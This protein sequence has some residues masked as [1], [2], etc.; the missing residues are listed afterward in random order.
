MK[1]AP[2]RQP[3]DVEDRV[4]EEVLSDGSIAGIKSAFTEYAEPSVM[5]IGEALV[6]VAF[7]LVLR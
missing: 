7:L 3:M 5:A 6:P 4:R 2:A 1:G